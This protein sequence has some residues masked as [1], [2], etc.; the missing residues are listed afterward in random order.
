MTTAQTEKV[1][2]PVPPTE[3]SNQCQDQPWPQPT[4]GRKAIASGPVTRRRQVWFQCRPGCAEWEPCSLL[5]SNTLP[6]GQA[7]RALVPGGWWRPAGRGA[8]ASATQRP[9]D[10]DKWCLHGKYLLPE[11]SSD[12]VLIVTFMH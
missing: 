12:H 7:G 8:A 11:V 9:G 6:E 1:R 5:I 2:G 4:R 3:A 10:L